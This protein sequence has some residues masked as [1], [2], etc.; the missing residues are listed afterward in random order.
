MELFDSLFM[1]TPL[2]LAVLFFVAMLAALSMRWR[3]VA[4]C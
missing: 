3:A 4:G 2:M 1:M